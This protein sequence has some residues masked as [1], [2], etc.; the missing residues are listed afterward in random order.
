MG[1][2]QVFDKSLCFK[3][4]KTAN[5]SIAIKFTQWVVSSPFLVITIKNKSSHDEIRLFKT[6]TME[7]G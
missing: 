4:T 3:L 7:Q 6:N 5:A 1:K 2:N